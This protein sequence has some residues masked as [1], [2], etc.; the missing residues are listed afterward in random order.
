MQSGGV[1]V[2]YIL[3]ACQVRVT[4]GDSG[5]CVSVT[6]IERLLISFFVDSVVF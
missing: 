6:F 5:L 4:A 1:Y 2:P 3:L